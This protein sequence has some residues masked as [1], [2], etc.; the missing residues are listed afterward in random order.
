MLTAEIV[1]LPDGTLS[2]EVEIYFDRD[3][4]DHFM[5]RLRHISE[6]KTDHLH[7]MSRS[8]GLADLDEKSH[9]PTSHIAHHLRL[10]LVDTDAQSV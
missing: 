3:G 9:K 10:T 4:F 7:L 5:D 1:F 8:W 2:G 6:G